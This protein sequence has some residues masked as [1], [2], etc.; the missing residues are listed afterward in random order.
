MIVIMGVEAHVC[1][2][3][4]AINFSEVKNY[5]VYGRGSPCFFKVGGSVAIV[6]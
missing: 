5:Y 2:K 3:K 4:G 1:L 6:W